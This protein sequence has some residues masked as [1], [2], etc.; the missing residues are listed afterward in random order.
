MWAAYRM[1]AFGQFVSG[2]ERNEF[3][4]LL[5]KTTRD[6]LYAGGDVFCLVGQRKD[7]G[8]RVPV[9]AVTMMPAQMQMWPH[10]YWFPWATA[11]NKIECAL[12]FLKEMKEKVN[13]VVVSIPKDV[14]FFQHLCRY[15]VIRRIGTGRGWLGDIDV[16]LFETVRTLNDRLSR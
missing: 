10:V 15:G 2:L 14:D 3:T 8:Q 13:L 12:F 6:I 7:N 1:G 4:E 9:A 11:R 16:T 5:L